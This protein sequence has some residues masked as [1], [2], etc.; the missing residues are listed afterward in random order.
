MK[1][2]RMICFCIL[3]LVMLI[4]VNNILA[5]TAGSG[6][7]E[8]TAENAVITE[9]QDQL[10]CYD[11]TF[12]NFHKAYTPETFNVSGVKSKEYQKLDGRELNDWYRYEFQDEHELY[13]PSG[14]NLMYGDS[15]MEYYSQVL[16]YLQW[17]LDTME[18]KGIEGFPLDEA[19]EKAD[20]LIAVL[21]IEYLEPD[22][23]VSLSHEDLNRIT[24][25]MRETFAGEP[26]VKYFDSFTKDIDAYYLTYRQVLN[27]IKTA[28]DPQAALV[29]TRDGIASLELSHVIDR[30]N[31]TTPLTKTLS[32]EEATELCSGKY[33]NE[34][35]SLPENM[36]ITNEIAEISVAH[37]FEF[38]EDGTD[39]YHAGV[40]PCWFF[41]GTQ[42]FIKD[43]EE[44][45][46]TSV[47]PIR[48]LYRIPDGHLF[49]GN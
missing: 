18:C 42:T 41:K 20:A 27:G 38:D 29:I 47:N 24:K 30:V 39:E 44:K 37:F 10:F 34:F 26:K 14:L 9:P 21:G 28:G 23:A 3:A 48:D 32:R 35:K 11:V 25:E 16:T 7:I 49:F 17:D 40:F 43:G 19:R 22:L 2:R 31:E 45:G 13:I 36:R 4:S 8:F 12:R 33:R 5:E 46:V 1:N 15:R 6:S